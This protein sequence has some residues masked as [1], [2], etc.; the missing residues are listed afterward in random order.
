[1]VEVELPIH[2]HFHKQLFINPVRII[3]LQKIKQ[4]GSLNSAAKALAISYQNAW[5]IVGEMNKIPTQ[6]IVL[7]QRGGNRGGGAKLSEYGEQVLK[8]YFYIEKQVLEFKKLLNVEIN[9]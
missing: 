4:T 9:L 1:M 3:L 2:I 6:P 8:E 5:T 7:K